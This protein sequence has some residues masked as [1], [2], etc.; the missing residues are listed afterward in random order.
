MLE[1]GFALEFIYILNNYLALNMSISLSP[2]RATARADILTGSVMG[3]G[4]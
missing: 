3:A 2:C 4:K 1:R